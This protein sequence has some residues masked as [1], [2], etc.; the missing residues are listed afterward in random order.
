M[1]SIWYD[2]DL[3]GNIEFNSSSVVVGLFFQRSLYT[4]PLP[5]NDRV[6]AQVYTQES[7]LVS[8]VFFNI[9]PVS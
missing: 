3:L 5:S 9:R 2:T 7:D 6:D 8:L 4:E 1:L